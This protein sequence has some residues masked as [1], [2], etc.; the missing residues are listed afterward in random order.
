MTQISPYRLRAAQRQRELIFEALAGRAEDDPLAVR[1]PFRMCIVPARMGQPAKSAAVGANDVDFVVVIALAG[2]RDQIAAW[3]PRGKRV[4]VGARRER[5]D[6]AA[7]DVDDAQAGAGARHGPEDEPL[8][9]R[10]PTRQPIVPL[11]AREHLQVAAVRANQRQVSRARGTHVGANRKSDA[12]SLRRPDGAADGR[13]G[14]HPTGLRTLQF[15]D[16]ATL[17]AFGICDEHTLGR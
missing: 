17:G 12:I 11:A 7:L 9:I 2:E 16:H 4:V 8:P 3:R 13:A 6:L 14:V 10:R 15:V 5:R 1:R